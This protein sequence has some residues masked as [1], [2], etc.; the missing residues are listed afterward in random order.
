MPPL[1][2]QKGQKS[3]LFGFEQQITDQF[4][5]CIFESFLLD[6]ES[7]LKSIKFCPLIVMTG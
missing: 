5:L 4:T 6:E 3:K 1:F 2:I 7:Y